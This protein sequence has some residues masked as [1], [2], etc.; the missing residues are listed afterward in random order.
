MATAERVGRVVAPAWA[1][2]ACSHPALSGVSRAHFGGLL[3]ELAPKWEAAR[4][5]ALRERR[6]GDRRRAAGAGPKQRLVFIDRLLITLVHLRL[7]LPHVALAQLYGVDRSTVSGAIREVRRLLAAR[8]SHPSGASTWKPSAALALAVSFWCLMSRTQS[9]ETL[10]M[11]MS[12]STA[13]ENPLWLTSISAL[14]FTTSRKLML[15]E[16]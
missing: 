5:S 1:R 3:E 9:K 2:A 11:V 8:M 7:G 14:V 10:A 15:P 13:N 6:G 12:T 4:E 16:R